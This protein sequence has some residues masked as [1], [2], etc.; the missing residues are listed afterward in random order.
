MENG[1]A[2]VSGE[3]CALRDHFP[4]LPTAKFLVLSAQFDQWPLNVANGWEE[5]GQFD[6]L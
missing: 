5:C 4:L 3:Q 2:G 6:N 1:C